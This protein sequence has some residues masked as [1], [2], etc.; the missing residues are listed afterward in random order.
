MPINLLNHLRNV[1][2]WYF[3][4]IKVG[5][6]GYGTIGRRVADGVASS[7]GMDIIGVSGRSYGRKMDLARMRGFP[8][9]VPSSSAHEFSERGFDVG[10]SL[11]DLYSEAD[12]IVDATPGKVAAENMPLYRA[13]G[14]KVI[15]Q[16]GEK[17]ELTGLSFSSL[18]NYEAAV[19]KDVCRVVSCNTT[20]LSRL[21][22]TLDRAYGVERVFVSLIRRAADPK[23]SKKGP[24]NAVKPVMGV[25]HHGPDVKTVMPHIDIY[26]MAVAI[27]HTLSHVHTL[28]VTLRSPADRDALVDL[29]RSTPR[30]LVEKGGEGFFDTAQIAEY[31]RDFRLRYDM[32]ELF[33]W[34]EPLDVVGSDVYIMADVHQESIVVPENVDCIK[35]MCGM[36][37]DKMRA[38]HGTD[39]TLGIAKS[40]SCYL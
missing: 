13:A 14:A 29:L 26:S 34:D 30:I 39:K 31:Y 8:V 24:I 27:P 28:K 15:V 20:G 37:S 12:I 3:M 6:V 2:W 40:D 25:S 16:G 19:G 10:G 18:A 32:P 23:E 36:E 1:K 17:H 11:E 33:I 7:S 35:A 22:S 21:I 9:F 4:T 5:I 38:I